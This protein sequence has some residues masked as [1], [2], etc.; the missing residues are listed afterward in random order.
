[1]IKTATPPQKAS[2]GRGSISAFTPSQTESV[3]PTTNI[4]TAASSAQ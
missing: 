4:P 3:P 2:S 1:M